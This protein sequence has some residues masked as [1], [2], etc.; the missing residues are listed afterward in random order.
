[1]KTML[2]PHCGWVG[3]DLRDCR[4]MELWHCWSGRDIKDCR[5]MELLGWVE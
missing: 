4:T 2:E 5:T 1:M 3:R